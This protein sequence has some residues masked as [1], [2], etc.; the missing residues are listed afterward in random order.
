MHNITKSPCKL[1]SNII[2]RAVATARTPHALCDRRVYLQ[3]RGLQ[4]YESWQESQSH[5]LP[6]NTKQIKWQNKGSGQ[7]GSNYDIHN[8]GVS[9]RR[10]SWFC[11]LC[12]TEI[13]CLLPPLHW[14]LL[15]C[16]YWF[17]GWTLHHWRRE[18]EAQR[19]SDY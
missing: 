7:S 15:P 9:I 13:F 5:G 10:K 6:G 16:L 1:L 3:E 2:G 4:A 14:L 8:S 12:S 17:R 19:K 18:S 11:P